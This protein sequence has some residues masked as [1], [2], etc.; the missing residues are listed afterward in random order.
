MK[1]RLMVA[2][3]CTFFLTTSISFGYKATF[4]PRLSVNGEY[5]DNISLTENKDLKKDDV[6]TTITPG[7]SAEILGENNGAE[8]SY[9]A[10]YAFYDE[11]DE[12]NTWRH[13]ANFKGWSQIAKNTRLNIRDNFTYTEDPIIHEDV[14]QIRTEDSELP[15]DS[16]V[17]KNRRVHYRNFAGVNIGHQFG[18]YHSFRIGY[19]HYL[20]KNKDSSDDD[21]QYHNPSAGLSYWF[22]PKW[23]FEVG[24]YYKRGEFES[25]D[26]VDLYNGFVGLNKRFGK[27]FVGYIRYSHI[28]VNTERETEDDTTFNPSIGFKYDIEKDISVL[29]DAGYF[30]NDFKLRK[31]VDAFNGSLRLIKE[32]EHGKINLSA[33]AGYDYSFFG[34]EKLG[35]NQ[36]YE[37]GVSG[38]YRLAK[39]VNGRIFGSYRNSE[40]T[41]ESDREDEIVR[42]GASL[43]WQALEWMSLDLGYRFRSVNSTIE[44]NE[45]DENRVNVRITLTPKQPFRTSR[46]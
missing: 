10:S 28:V 13:N 11:F 20:R 35:F 2:A 42:V 21:N 8:I 18:K 15:I 46:Y 44:T 39:F 1:S 45:Y 31:D 4:I 14:A 30:Y 32:F 41:D 16:T 25:S 3:I 22:S 40:Y 23:G 19:N 29:F 34:E 27:H 38:N 26:D 7:F 6:I 5:T 36:F 17:R 43:T 9:D 37:G 12:F 33:L 24:G